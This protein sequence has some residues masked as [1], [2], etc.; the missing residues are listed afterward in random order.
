[1]DI[2][3]R[4]AFVSNV[5]KE[6]LEHTVCVVSLQAFQYNLRR[7]LLSLMCNELSAAKRGGLNTK[8]HR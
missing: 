4:T 2:F 5:P 8:T 3:V 1:M 6:S 7:S